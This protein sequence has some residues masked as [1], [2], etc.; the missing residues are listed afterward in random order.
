MMI[1]RSDIT[2]QLVY[3]KTDLS[4]YSCDLYTNGDLWVKRDRAGYEALAAV[5]SSRVIRALG[6][7]TVEYRPCFLAVNRYDVVTACVSDNFASPPFTIINI[8]KLLEQV[9][10]NQLLHD[11]ASLD[12]SFERLDYVCK[13]LKGIIP[14][15]VLLNGMA[16]CIWLDSVIL[17]TNRSFY[18][19]LLANEGDYWKFINFGYGASLLSDIEEFPMEAPIQSLMHQASAKPFST[20]FSCQLGLFPT[21]LPKKYNADLSI[22]ISDL[23]MYFAPEHI[24]RCC[25]VLKKSLAAK[26][27]SVQFQGGK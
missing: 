11:I 16:E 21:R 12:F 23:P 20:S 1:S 7:S 15:D 19:M 22:D 6:F 17:N 2:S 10:S 14:E 13:A 9:S 4:E 25:V 8:G 26:G 18:N 3:E 27:I 5:L 24:K